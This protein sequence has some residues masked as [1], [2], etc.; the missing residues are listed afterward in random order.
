MLVVL[1]CNDFPQGRHGF[2]QLYT[3]AS[4]RVQFILTKSLSNHSLTVNGEKLQA[5]LVLGLL[6]D[7]PP[8]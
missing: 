2:I 4:F 7:P 3:L 1:Y 8:L 6:K 5:H